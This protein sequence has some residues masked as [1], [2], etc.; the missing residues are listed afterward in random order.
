MTQNIH[1]PCCKETFQVEDKKEVITLTVFTVGRKSLFL[2]IL[3]QQKE[4]L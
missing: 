3:K 1:C 4:T 2:Q